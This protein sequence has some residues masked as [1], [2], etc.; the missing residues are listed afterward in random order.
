[1][2]QEDVVCG[3]HAVLTALSQHPERVA[4]VWISAERAD[5]RIGRVLEAAR[6]TKIK[7]H[8]VPRAKLDDLAGDARHQGVVARLRVAP[9]G[10]EKELEAFLERPPRT[11]LVLV[12]DGVQDPHNFGA[13]LRVADA[14]GAQAVIVPRDRSAP[15]SAA[16]RRAA[17]GAAETVPIFEVTNLARSLDRLK[18]AGV[19]LYG[20]EQGAGEDL[21]GVDLT[22]PLA[23]V[24]GG[25]GQGLRRLTRERCDA[26]VRIPMVGKVESLNVSVAAGVVL[27]EVLRQRL[28][29]PA[30]AVRR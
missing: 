6:A 7:F 17:S 5:Q 25:E 15:L 14:A 22:G 19:W 11:P 12:L 9:V 30:Q 8:R 28:A 23:L 1:M 13:C 10:G 26:L 16:A 4:A 20:A 18:A 24:L 3:L 2:R 21:Y 29:N 27:Y